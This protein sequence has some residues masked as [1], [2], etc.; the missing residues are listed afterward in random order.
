MYFEKFDL[1]LKKIEKH[2]T[3]KIEIYTIAYLFLSYACLTNTKKKSLT[4]TVVKRLEVQEIL[5]KAC[6]NLSRLC[7]CMI[8]SSNAF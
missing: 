8:Y 4:S 5:V 2:F 1:F 3:L 6:F 7:P